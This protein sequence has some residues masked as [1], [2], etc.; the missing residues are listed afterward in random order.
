MTDSDSIQSH[1]KNC[2][3]SF[4]STESWGSPEFIFDK[5]SSKLK[6]VLKDVRF[7]SISGFSSFPPHNRRNLKWNRT[8]V[9]AHSGFSSFPR[10]YSKRATSKC[11]FVSIPIRASLHFHNTGAIYRLILDNHVSMPIRAF[12]HFYLKNGVCFHGGNGCVNALLGFPSFLQHPSGTRRNKAFSRPFLQVF[13]WKFWKQGFSDCILYC[14]Q[15]V[16][17]LIQITP[18]HKTSVFLLYYAFSVI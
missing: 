6:F 2:L 13:I 1:L 15:F 14:S 5:I 9:N 10:R 3:S 12:L 18:A 7:T 8:S 4:S 16:H 11:G 17:I